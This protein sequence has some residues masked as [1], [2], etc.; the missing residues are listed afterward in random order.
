MERVSGDQGSKS[1]CSGCGHREV[2]ANGY[3]SPSTAAVRFLRKILRPGV[4]VR[5]GE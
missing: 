1:F 5:V 4:S 3:P 2:M